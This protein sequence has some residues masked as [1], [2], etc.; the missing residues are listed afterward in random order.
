[1][2]L[3]NGNVY[4]SDKAIPINFETRQELTA[5]ITGCSIVSGFAFSKFS[6]MASH[7]VNSIKLPLLLKVIYEDKRKIEFIINL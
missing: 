1:M 4:C 3:L 5:M 6:A 7:I 2:Q